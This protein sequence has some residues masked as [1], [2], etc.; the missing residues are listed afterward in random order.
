[1]LVLQH[2]LDHYN[3]LK[4]HHLKK[5]TSKKA[6]VTITQTMQ[7]LTASFT[8]RNALKNG[9]G[10]GDELVTLY[11]TFIR[12]TKIQLWAEDKIGKRKWYD[13][14]ICLIMLVKCLCESIAV[15]FTGHYLT[16][17]VSVAAAAASTGG[18]GDPGVRGSTNVATAT[19]RRRNN[20]AAAERIEKLF[21]KLFPLLP[22]D[23]DDPDEEKGGGNHN[24]N[25]NHNH[26]H[27]MSSTTDKSDSKIGLGP[28]SRWGI[29]AWLI[30]S[31]KKAD[32]FLKD[33]EKSSDVSQQDEEKWEHMDQM[34]VGCLEALRQLA[35][36]GKCI[37]ARRVS[38]YVQQNVYFLWLTDEESTKGWEAD[39][40]VSVIYNW[41][42][43]ALLHPSQL[44]Q[45]DFRD[46]AEKTLSK[47]RHVYHDV[48]YR[49]S[50]QQVTLR[51][52]K[53][54]ASSSTIH[55]KKGG[56]GGGGG[57]LG[58]ETVLWYQTLS[59][60][61]M[62]KPVSFQAPSKPGNYRMLLEMFKGDSH[63]GATKAAEIHSN[64]KFDG[65]GFVQGFPSSLIRVQVPSAHILPSLLLFFHPTQLLAQFL[66]EAISG[67]SSK[68]KLCVKAILQVFTTDTKPLSILPQCPQISEMIGDERFSSW[69]ATHEF[70]DVAE[71]NM[72]KLLF[73]SL[74]LLGSRERSTRFLTFQMLTCIVHDWSLF[75]EQDQIRLKKYSF[76]FESGITTSAREHAI[77]IS[78]M[79]SRNVPGFALNV[80]A[81]SFNS[82][83]KLSDWEWTLTFLLPWARCIDLNPPKIAAAAAAAAAV[84]NESSIP[85][86]GSGTN[87]RGRRANSMALKL[88]KEFS[89]SSAVSSS[90]ARVVAAAYDTKGGG[91][92]RNYQ[93]TTSPTTT[94]SQHLSG[95]S[96]GNEEIKGKLR[97][98][99]RTDNKYNASSRRNTTTQHNNNN[100][101]RRINISAQSITVVVGEE[102]GT[103][104]LAV[105]AA[106]GGGG[107]GG[108][109]TV[110]INDHTENSS[111][112]ATSTNKPPSKQGGA[113]TTTTTTT[114][115]SSSSS[116]TDHRPP[117]HT[118]IGISTSYTIK[119][120]MNL[121]RQYKLLY[122]LL[123]YIINDRYR[124]L[125][126]DFLVELGQSEDN[127]VT[128]VSFMLG[129]IYEK[130][131]LKNE[132]H[133]NTK[134]ELS[135][136]SRVIQSAIFAIY[137]R[138]PRCRGFILEL[139][140]QCMR[141]HL[142]RNFNTTNIAGSMN[143]HVP[144]IGQLQRSRIRYSLYDILSDEL[145]AGLKL[146][147]Y[148]MEKVSREQN[149]IISAMVVEFIGIDREVVRPW[150]PEMVVY[151][152]IALTKKNQHI[153]L[154][155]VM[156]NLLIRLIAAFENN[157]QGIVSKTKRA[158]D[159]LE[160]L[161]NS[162]EQQGGGAIASDDGTTDDQNT[163]KSSREITSHLLKIFRTECP[164]CVPQIGLAAF[165]WGVLSRDLSIIK[166]A[167][168]AYQCLL[169][170]LEGELEKKTSSSLKD[171]GISV[172]GLHGNGKSAK[173]SILS[174]TEGGKSISNILNH[175]HHLAFFGE[176]ELVGI[177]SRVAIHTLLVKLLQI[178]ETC[179]KYG[180]FLPHRVQGLKEHAQA[181]LSFLLYIT[182][183][184]SSV[185]RLHR[186]PALL[187]AATAFLRCDIDEIYDYGLDI[188]KYM[189]SYQYLTHRSEIPQNFWTY[190]EGWHPR[191]TGVLLSL[192][193]G[194][195]RT[196][197]QGKTME[198][199]YRLV[200]LPCDSFVGFDSTSPI[201]QVI[202]ILIF[203]PWLHLSLRAA[204]PSVGGLAYQP[205]DNNNN[206]NSIGSN[207]AAATESTAVRTY[208]TPNKVLKLLAKMVSKTSKEMTA[209]FEEY[210]RPEMKGSSSK[211]KTR[212]RGDLFLERICAAIVKAYLPT[213]A[214]PCAN[215]LAVVC[216]GDCKHYHPTIFAIVNHMLT[217][218]NAQTYIMAF[219]PIIE[220]AQTAIIQRSSNSTV[221]D[222]SFDS[223]SS[224]A[225][226]QIIRAV[227][228]VLLN[229]QRKSNLYRQFD[230]IPIRNLANTVSA[231][232]QI[233]AATPLC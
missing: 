200:L 144:S 173:S 27:Q 149:R 78:E 195:M 4:T 49:L 22:S 216:K 134:V 207:T 51:T 175:Q 156:C 70:R 32:D 88:T 222:S 80:I 202:T 59:S 210:A 209:L 13:T 37:Y 18:G 25:H 64:Y 191:F 67:E 114:T 183:H 181:I 208:L 89:T 99:Q 116:S 9:F 135:R 218:P 43:L 71:R 108:D 23:P 166:M 46:F 69:S 193:P 141:K 162:F 203:L 146:A 184:L 36:L 197:T 167:F 165:K 98:D 154:R 29:F 121:Q 150:L 201:R 232:K 31:A 87:T 139:F 230:V 54:V 171:G 107:S 81:L 61:D 100:E 179:K 73:L 136:Y 142:T 93:S 219:Q 169:E 145:K 102:E 158:T 85:T 133:Y 66:A 199:V 7:M 182:K 212:N 15:T 229:K 152:I 24:H 123:Q 42:E 58:G 30:K 65:T 113:T 41:D 189:K 211:N 39:D 77:K 178:L 2:M 198:L 118:N 120:K 83:G 157:T 187:W 74:Y 28:Y 35:S 206:N 117:L 82:L 68:A 223:E 160:E 72:D 228:E 109:M 20:A 161:V 233:L 38:T 11:L 76:A 79:L 214:L 84:A 17:R 26:H 106:Q 224:S 6:L 45:V 95:S 217:Q 53:G 138:V 33:L 12:S 8:H 129:K 128:I 10:T 94:S 75:S 103:N 140:F 16:Q 130:I 176:N 227:M 127:I 50:L 226:A 213:Y 225:S 124:D 104:V 112:T 21:E 34:K 110:S 168:T 172:I 177:E 131:G 101:H 137:S 170:P 185:H 115:S 55:E 92:P 153:S 204:D 44:V 96:D 132:A 90:S 164:I 91:S 105:G 194:M 126:V 205:L 159:E 86:S 231:L 63:H 188:M 62:E 122:D 147:Q 52:T 3:N 56:G 60:S 190:T 215:Y 196:K 48:V 155:D 97:A 192:I 14:Q 5:R 57:G 119:P 163:N 19:E 47:Y 151:A 125:M 174:Q 148:R 186:H 40:S 221:N 143:I 111:A 1:M 180:H 220:I